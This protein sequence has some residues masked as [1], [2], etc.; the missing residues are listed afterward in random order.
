[1]LRIWINIVDLGQ[2]VCKRYNI[3]NYAAFIGF[4]LLDDEKGRH[5]FKTC[6]SFF[7][8]RLCLMLQ[9]RGI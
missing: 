2:Q 9:R 1:M 7:N 8:F 4:E 5:F 6:R 3:K